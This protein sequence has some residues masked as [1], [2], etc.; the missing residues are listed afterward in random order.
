M[1]SDHTHLSEGDRAECWMEETERRQK[2]KKKGGGGGGLERNEWP[3][4]KNN[5]TRSWMKICPRIKRRSPVPDSSLKSQNYESLKQKNS[6]RYKSQIYC[7][8]SYNP[9]LLRNWSRQEGV[10]RESQLSFH[11]ASKVSNII[12]E[13][14]RVIPLLRW[15]V[16]VCV[17]VL[18]NGDT[19]RSFRVLCRHRSAAVFFLSLP[20]N[21]QWVMTFSWHVG[22]KWR[23]YP[24]LVYKITQE[25]H[26]WHRFIQLKH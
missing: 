14:W 19:L 13:G 24:R 26:K 6:R 25:N 5:E 12:S 10:L 3:G 17:C 9:P 20:H 2:K 4:R 23:V 21:W 1:T 15:G 16:C 22:W 8:Y 11:T 7:S 18:P